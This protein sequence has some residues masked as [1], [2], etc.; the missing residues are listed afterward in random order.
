MKNKIDS[1]FLNLMW[2]FP[3]LTF[4]EATNDNLI[5]AICI[6]PAM[7]LISGSWAAGD[8]SQIAYL[9]S[10]LSDE[11]NEKTGVNELAAVMSFLYS[12]YI[13]LT[14]LVAF[15]LSQAVDRFKESGHPEFGFMTICIVMSVIS[16][17][18]C[19]IYLTVAKFKPSIHDDQQQIQNNDEELHTVSEPA[20][21]VNV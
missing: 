2:I 5:F 18:I 19:V 7:V 21:T 20:T 17:V 9:Q 11:P 3:F 14:T 4:D 15:G 13:V 16:F 12:C 1:L 8:I 6:V 10:T